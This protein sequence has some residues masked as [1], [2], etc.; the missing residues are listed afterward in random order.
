MANI[1]KKYY[2]VQKVN[3]VYNSY[4]AQPFCIKQALTATRG[5]HISCLESRKGQCF[6]GKIDWKWPFF[7]IEAVINFQQCLSSN[8]NNLLWHYSSNWVLAGKSLSNFCTTAL[9]LPQSDINFFL[10]L[11]SFL[12]GW[13][14]NKDGELKEHVDKKGGN[15]LWRRHTKTELRDGRYL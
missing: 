10:H 8:D 15:I 14:V 5:M 7:E 9:T 2:H 6:I 11:N 13:K 1:F 4:H 3:C 12:M